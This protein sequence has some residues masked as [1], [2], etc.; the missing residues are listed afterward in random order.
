MSVGW[1][2]NCDE[3]YTEIDGECYYQS[4]L[5]VLQDFID[6]NE[7]LN[8]E[9]PLEIGDQEWNNTRL[10]YLGL[11]NRSLTTIPDNIGNLN[12]LEYLFLSSNQFSILPESI[13]NLSSMK[14]LFLSHNQFSILPES[15]GNLSSLETLYL[16]SNQ[17][18]ILPD[19]IC[20]LSD[21]YIYVNDN[22]L[23]PPYP[24]CLSEED[25]GYQNTSECSEIDY[26]DL[27]SDGEI[28]ILDV[29]IVLNCILEDEG[30][31]YICMDYN[32]DSEVNILDV[33]IMVNIILD[34]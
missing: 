13:G 20:N 17:L 11:G 34:V 23:C 4:D 7:S 9:E 1:G 16:H 30:C 15:I 8:G 24:E 21:C 12:H 22:Q 29:I 14:F 31:D 2:Q 10:T 19:T 32:E 18:F 26:C 25:I 27:N 6:F 5:D 33:I 28:N 3:G